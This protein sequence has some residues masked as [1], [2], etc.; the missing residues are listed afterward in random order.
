MKL[1]QDA[2]DDNWSTSLSHLKARNSTLR[3]VIL[4]SS[5][6]SNNI[7]WGQIT[8]RS[9]SRL[10]SRRSA[11][12]RSSPGVHE[13]TAKKHKGEPMT[14]PSTSTKETT[15]FKEWLQQRERESMLIEEDGKFKNEYLT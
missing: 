11:A 8:G 13:F 1:Q 2:G 4:V 14:L 9:K 12:K 10:K 6:F 15:H 7:L 5:I 3:K